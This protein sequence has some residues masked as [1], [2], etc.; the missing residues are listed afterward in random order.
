MQEILIEGLGLSF[1]REPSGDLA[2]GLEA[3]HSQRRILHVG[4]STGR[5]IM[6]ALMQRVS[7]QPNINILLGHTAVDLI[8]FPH[9]A[10]DPMAV[11]APIT[12][13]G[14]YV[15]DQETK[16]VHRLLAGQTILATGGLGRST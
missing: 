8:T 7:E 6:S 15:F 14:A 2:L 11:Y 5:S 9:H 1:D 16:K 13:H 12:C 3:A 4:D 10:L